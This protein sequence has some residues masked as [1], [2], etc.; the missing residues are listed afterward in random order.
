MIELFFVIDRVVYIENFENIM[1]LILSENY[2]QNFF[3]RIY[4]YSFTV[5]LCTRNV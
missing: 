3:S 1:E 4:L 5:S 2:I